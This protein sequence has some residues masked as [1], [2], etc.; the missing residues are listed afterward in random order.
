[1][2][3]GLP[4]M[5]WWLAALPVLMGLTSLLIRR[6]GK[7][8]TKMA[9]RS[10][11]PA[12]MAGR[13]LKRIRIKNLLRILA[14]ALAILALARPQWGFHWEKV[15]RRGLTIIVA[16]DTSKSMLAQD[17]PPSRIEQAKLGIEDL[18]KQLK[19][20]RIG[21]V[22]FAG[23]AFL[24]C[25]ATIDYAAFMMMLNDVYCGII[26][27][28]GTD[29]H[30]ALKTS[31]KSFDNDSQADKVIILI[32]DGEHLDNPGTED[33]LK[34]IPQIKAQGIRVFAIGVGTKEGTIIDTPD[35]LVKDSKGDVIKTA[36][37]E[38]LLEK[39][40]LGTGGFYVRSIPGDFGIERIYREGIAPLQRE[41]QESRMARIYHERF[42][43]F[44]GASL[45]LLLI[46]AAISPS[47]KGGLK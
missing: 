20:D 1:M 12:L 46:E 32:S 24:Q 45:L 9:D 17:I 19:G 22:A 39:I 7:L 23:G 27:L 25:P 40:A 29:I 6:R 4:N 2:K 8:L 31:M 10:L 5:L 16:L 14:L 33:P 42:P 38:N 36:L 41:D 26:P 44:I 11:W 21:L 13:S 28:G 43:W 18:V 47:K 34:L 30:Q 35:G 3:W 15:T 37:N